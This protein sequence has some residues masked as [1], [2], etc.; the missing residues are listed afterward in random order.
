[1]RV[2]WFLLLLLLVPGCDDMHDQVSLQ[3][4]EAPRL[5]SP[6]QAVPIS[7][8]ERLVFGQQLAN[9]QPNSRESRQRGANLYAINCELCHGNK[10]A[11]PG[12][13]GKELNPPPPQLRDSHLAAYDVATLY[14]L[15][16]LGVGRMPPFQQR[17]TQTERWHLVNYLRSN[18]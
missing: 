17:L 7:G 4:Q 1:M 12:P 6:A 3:P 2:H 10:D 14:Q 16:S 8:K 11:H 5:S 9:P 13:V 18:D 15:M